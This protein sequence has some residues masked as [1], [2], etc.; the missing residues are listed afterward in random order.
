MKCKWCESEYFISN[1]DKVERFSRF[2]KYQIERRGK[3][4]EYWRP[5]ESVREAEHCGKRKIASPIK[6]TV[7][8]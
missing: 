6:P 3:R 1:N 7:R 4:A 2:L 5:R 8:E